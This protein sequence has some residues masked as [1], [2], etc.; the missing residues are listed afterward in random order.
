[1]TVNVEYPVVRYIAAEGDGP[2]HFSWTSDEATEIK[3]EVDRVLQVEGQQYELEDYDPEEGGSVRFV[4]TPESG[5]E[6]LIYRETP[7][8]Q[9]LDY[10]EGEPFPAETHE[11]QMDK[12]TRILQEINAGRGIGG[13]PDLNA[14]QQPSFVEIENSAGTNA[15]IYPWACD[16]EI[17]G[18]FIGAVVDQAPEDGAATLRP[19]GFMWIATEEATVPGGGIVFPTNPVTVN[20]GTDQ[21]F[22]L[23]HGAGV[24]DG[25][26]PENGFF[27]QSITDFSGNAI[28]TGATELYTPDPI[29]ALQLFWF[30]VAVVSND[31]VQTIPEYP[32]DTWIDSYLDKSNNESGYSRFR[33]RSIIPKTIQLRVDIAPDD[34]TG[35][36]DQTQTVSRVYTVNFT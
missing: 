23:W 7:I 18:V 15:T 35:Q 26:R 31:G 14:N 4:P 21:N 29:T 5:A 33:F 27:F 34:G 24:Q 6:I 8:T 2:Y 22:D 16:E 17:A 30:R 13:R 25:S 28:S 9:Q 11:R 36:P 19:D 12:D 32:L 3:V 10:I 20:L 1:M